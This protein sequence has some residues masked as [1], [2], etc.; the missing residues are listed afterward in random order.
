MKLVLKIAV[1]LAVLAIIYK[2]LQNLDLI[3]KEDLD[4]SDLDE[5]VI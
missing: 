5:E 4:L 3:G 1:V 2:V